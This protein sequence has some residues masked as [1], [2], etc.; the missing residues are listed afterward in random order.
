MKTTYRHD[1]TEAKKRFFVL[2]GTALLG[3]LVLLYPPLRNGVTGIFYKLTPSAWDEGNTAE[4]NTVGF[5]GGFQSRQILSE[6][7]KNLQDEVL[8]MQAQVL[9]RNLLAEKVAQLEERF[10]RIERDDRVVANVLAGPGRI[11]YDTLIIDAGSA[12]GIEQSDNVAYAG[13]GVIGRVVEVYESSAKIRLYSSPQEEP[14]VLIGKRAI[15][16]RAQGK[17]MGNFEAFVPE[18][19]Q[20]VLGDEVT[21]PGTMLV[22]GTVDAIERRPDQPFSRVLFR[23]PFNISSITTVEVIVGEKKI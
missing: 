17:G 23:S 2:L 13:A 18:D 22:L 16:V 7:N 20:V 21:L 6:E 11:S 5:F 10:G 12:Q 9:D 14:F 4:S 1:N 8:R 19:S 3:G 15:P